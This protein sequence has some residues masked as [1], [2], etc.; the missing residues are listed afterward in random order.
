MGEVASGGLWD[1]HRFRQRIDEPERRLRLVWPSRAVDFGSLDEA[2]V[3]RA[4]A[5]APASRGGVSA[6]VLIPIAFD[7]PSGPEVLVTRRARSLRHHAGEIAFPGGRA[8]A[9]ETLVETARRE[10]EEEVGLEASAARVL[11]SV[12]VGYTRSSAYAFEALVAAVPRETMLT[13]QPDEV[14]MAAWVPLATLFGP[15][16]AASEL[17]YDDRAGWLR[18]WLFD[19][20]DDLLWGASARVVAALA[21]CL[22]AT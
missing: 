2:S 18:V 6:A 21:Q 14:E 11:G 7:G 1:L 16:R 17:W 13:L 4:L 8:R 20:G 22:G 10:A 3:R 12:G 9:G 15:E 5:P 19:L